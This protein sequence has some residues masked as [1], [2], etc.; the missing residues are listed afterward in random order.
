MQYLTETLKTPLS[1]TARMTGYILDNSSEVD[2][3]RV[4]PAVI[5]CPG[6][7]YRFTSDREAEPIAVKMSSFGLQAF[8]VR[9]SVAPARYPTAL[10]ELAAAVK[11]VRENA[12]QYHVDPN[13]IIVLG[14]SAGG[15]LAA[16][17]ATVWNQPILEQGGFTAADCQPNA[18]VLGYP[19]ITSGTFAHEDSFRALLGEDATEQQLS[20]VSLEK[21][22]SENTPPTFIWT[23]AD[24][25]VVPAENSLMFAQALK[26][27]GVSCELHV[28][29]HGYH[30]MSLGTKETTNPAAGEMIS[31]T[32]AIW[33]E[34]LANWV[35]EVFE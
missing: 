22:V 11:L 24:D 35:N 4:R 28:F 32:V 25:E 19:V 13:K 29:R 33:T 2:E 10:Y 18:L 7:G 3:K 30:G 12:S 8:V 9:Y 26:K 31:P 5:I 21:Q 17:L 15:H 14:F 27:A 6:G 20:A 23:V 1:E 34:L 16:N